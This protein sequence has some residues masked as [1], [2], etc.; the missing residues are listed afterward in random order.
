MEDSPMP[1][2]R[3][4][5]RLRAL[6]ALLLLIVG[7]CL[8]RSVSLDNID[9]ADVS[10]SLH[11]TVPPSASEGAEAPELSAPVAH[12]LPALREPVTESLRP[13]DPLSVDRSGDESRF[14]ELT[15]LDAQTREP[16]SGVRVHLL[17]TIALPEP[18][19]VEQAEDQFIVGPSPSLVPHSRIIALPYEAQGASPVSIRRKPRSNAWVTADGYGWANWHVEKGCPES[20]V[21]LLEPAGQLS[22]TLSGAIED[23]YLTV[24]VSIYSE[25][26]DQPIF[27]S[28][29]QN[30]SRQLVFRGMPSGR[31]E[32]HATANRNGSAVSLAG[33]ATATTSKGATATVAIE[34][35]AEA[36]ELRLRFLVPI[37]AENPQRIESVHLTRMT[38]GGMSTHSLP[39]ES[40]GRF[41]D[42]HVYVPRRLPGALLGNAVLT[43]SPHG[44]CETRAISQLVPIDWV[45]EL[46]P[47]PTHRVMVWDLVAS[48]PYQGPIALV[49][50]V[51][52]PDDPLEGFGPRE[53]RRPLTLDESG[54]AAFLAPQSG[55]RFSTEPHAIVIEPQEPLWTGA[56]LVPVELRLA[57]RPVARL[58][59]DTLGETGGFL[60]LESFGGDKCWLE[61]PH[62]NHVSP[63]SFREPVDRFARLGSNSQHLEL[64]FDADGPHW[65]VRVAADESGAVRRTPVELRRGQSVHLAGPDTEAIE[66]GAPLPYAPRLPNSAK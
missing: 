52:G 55:F 59:F 64:A 13:N 34:L 8:L 15:V 32:I 19:N 47:I 18:Q 26:S 17:Q 9:A 14:I 6:T 22:V 61:D 43:V 5:T 37:D 65:L 3:V 27:E 49:E 20:V 58:S 60:R 63:I 7:L 45:V 41:G 38:R 28:Q 66:T 23:R 2:V 54:S 1:P 50:R 10:L 46:P 25:G 29:Q 48:R 21:V 36:A 62:G 4:A 40:A 11:S 24:R 57:V 39:L 51:G 53:I 44:I 31:A 35:A 42:F 30:T 33:R 12:A 56:Q 16:L